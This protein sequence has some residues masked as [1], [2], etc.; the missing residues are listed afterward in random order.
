MVGSA[1]SLQKVE[2]LKEIARQEI[3]NM[4]GQSSLFLP[5]QDEQIEEAFSLLSNSSIRTVRPEFVFGKI[6]DHIGFGSI[7]E[8]LFRHLVVSRLVFP[9]SKLKIISL[10]LFG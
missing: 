4:Q 7:N 2:R 6:F 1:T 8:E 3:E 10:S 9:L 5:E